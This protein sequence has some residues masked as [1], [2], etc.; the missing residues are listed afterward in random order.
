MLQKIVSISIGSAPQGM[1]QHFIVGAPPLFKFNEDGTSAGNEVPDS[2]IVSKIT[3]P[4]IDLPRRVFPDPCYIVHFEGSSRRR[5]IP[6]GSIVDVCY[7]N[8]NKEAA[9]ADNVPDLPAE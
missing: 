9:A 3:Y 4:L 1:P 2:P 5:V 7:M 6:I 8:V